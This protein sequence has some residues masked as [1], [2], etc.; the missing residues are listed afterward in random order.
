M[1]NPLLQTANPVLLQLRAASLPYLCFLFKRIIKK[2][3]EV[4]KKE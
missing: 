3:E 1:I 2:Y 4:M